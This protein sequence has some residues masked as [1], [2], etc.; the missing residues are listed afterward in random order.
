M[1]T[2]LVFIIQAYE[3]KTEA[4]QLIDWVQL[5]LIDQTPEQ[6]IKRAKELIKKSNYRVS[7]VIE[8]FHDQK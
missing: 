5:E 3:L 1:K 4:G 6:A 2:Y 8:K 7:A